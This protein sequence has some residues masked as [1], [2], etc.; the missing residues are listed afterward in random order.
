ML[1]P[2]ALQ[3]ADSTG[4]SLSGLVGRHG[5]MSTPQHDMLCVVDT[6][7][8]PGSPL[9]QNS[10]VSEDW[11]SRGFRGW[12]RALSLGPSA[13]SAMSTFSW[14]TTPPGG[15]QTQTPSGSSSRE[16]GNRGGSKPRNLWLFQ[17][18]LSPR[19]EQGKLFSGLRVRM[20]VVTGVVER[21]QELKSS[22]LYQRVQGRPRNQK[23]AAAT[24]AAAAAAI[25]AD[26]PSLL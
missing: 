21:G 22:A 3:H 10:S 26:W 6:N 12:G 25:A 14:G 18:L 9:P 23:Y 13:S 2:T 7:A 20:G 5:S 1:P 16:K 15:V 11:G 17:Q 19:Q 8:Y 4:S 24:A